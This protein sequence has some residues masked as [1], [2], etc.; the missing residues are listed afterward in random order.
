MH[1][2]DPARVVL[3][4]L[5]AAWR[6]RLRGAVAPTTPTATM[7]ASASRSVKGWVRGLLYT[8]PALRL[9]GHTV[10]VVAQRQ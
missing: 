3:K 8:D 2:Y 10:L 6:R 1:P 4:A 5:P 7:R 9:F